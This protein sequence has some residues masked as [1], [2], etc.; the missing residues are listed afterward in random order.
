MSTC[1]D[2]GNV[3]D[4]KLYPGFVHILKANAKSDSLTLARTY[5]QARLRISTLKRWEDYLK[6]HDNPNNSLLPISACLRFEMSLVFR[7]SLQE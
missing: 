4:L 5:K 7:D 6:T 2:C 1:K 3:S